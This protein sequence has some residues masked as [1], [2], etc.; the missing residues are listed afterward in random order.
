MGVVPCGASKQHLLLD[1]EEEERSEA[2]NKAHEEET[3]VNNHS[4]WRQDVCALL[5]P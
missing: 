5:T 1:L 2:V 4:R 3:K